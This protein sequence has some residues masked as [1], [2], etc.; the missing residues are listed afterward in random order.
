MGAMDALKYGSYMSGLYGSMAASSTTNTDPTNTTTS[1][2]GNKSPYLQ[3]GQTDLSPKSYDKSYE[4]SN[5]GSAST[6]AEAGAASGGLKSNY[7]ADSLSRSYFDASRAYSEA[8]TGKS[9]TPD[10]MN[11]A[12]G[13]ASADSPEAMKMHSNMSSDLQP[14][15]SQQSQQ[16]NMGF[17][18][19]Q[20]NPKLQMKIAIFFVTWLYFIGLL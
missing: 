2:S 6:G 10:S 4:S 15:Q 11:S 14:Q 20:V 3:P 12:G 8:A 5:N 19:L 18:S 9:Y 13:R 7:T 1:S 16:H 17:N